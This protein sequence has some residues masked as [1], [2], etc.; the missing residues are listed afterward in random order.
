VFFISL[1][2]YQNVDVEDGLAWAIWN[3]QHKLWQKES[4]GIKL[5]V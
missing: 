3:L 5:A 1:E 4:P 2:N